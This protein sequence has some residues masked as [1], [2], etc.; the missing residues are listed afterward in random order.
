MTAGTHSVFLAWRI[1]EQIEIPAGYNYGQKNQT[2]TG[3]QTLYTHTHIDELVVDL[4]GLENI[5]F[6]IIRRMK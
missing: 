6:R 5:V 4:Y 3:G 2:F 1:Y